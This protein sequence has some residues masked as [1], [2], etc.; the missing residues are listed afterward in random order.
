MGDEHF[1]DGAAGT[2][3]TDA[4]KQFLEL[5]AGGDP[6]PGESWQEIQETLEGDL[7]CYVDHKALS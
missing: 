6:G 1:R 5:T 2:R 7:T 4:A 3:R